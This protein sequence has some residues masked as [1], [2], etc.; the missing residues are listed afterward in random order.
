MSRVGAKPVLVP[1][2]VK[3]ALEGSHLT[4]TGPK[5]ELAR[6]FH[7]EMQI[8]LRDSSLVVSRPSD[9]NQHRALHG[10]TRTLLANMIQGVTQG[11]QKG[12]EIS[13]VGYRAQIAGE[14]L[15]I[16]IG[17]SHPIEVIPPKGISLTAE[18]LRINIAGI[19]KELV[20][21]VAARIRALR[22]AE[23]YKGKGI[24]YVGERVRRKAGK[25]GKVSAK[26]A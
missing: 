23:A 10:L 18:G 9:S 21:E 6:D 26:K 20:G 8:A 3:V 13:G 11:F 17:F 1:K 19:D 24:R 12:L 25:A 2:E 22:P 4:I 14:K 16:Q 15:T 7:P 5:G